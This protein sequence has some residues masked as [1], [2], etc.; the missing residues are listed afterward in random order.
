MYQHDYI[1][2][3]IEQIGA[4]LIAL[5]KMILGRGSTPGAIDRELRKVLQQVGFDLD[6]A[7]LADADTLQ[8][9]IAPTGELEPGRGWMVAETIYLDGLDAQVEGRTT[10]AR[11]SFQKAVSLYRLF[12]PGILLPPGFPEAAERITE[13]ETRLA[14]LE[15]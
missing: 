14:D 6:L 1:L 3:M 15:D 13:I 12:D 9:M 11:V 10:E 2:R 8:R 7:R 5:R 4:V